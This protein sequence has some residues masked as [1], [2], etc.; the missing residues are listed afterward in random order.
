MSL[1]VGVIGAGDKA[2]GLLKSLATFTGL[3]QHG[4]RPLNFISDQQ[5]SNVLSSEQIRNMFL[6]GMTHR[7]GFLVNSYELTGPVHIPP[8]SICEPRQLP[9][10]G[11]ET[12]PV[13][14][15]D[16]LEGTWI[17]ICSYTGDCQRVC[18]PEDIRKTDWKTSCET[19]CLRFFIYP[20]AP[21][22]IFLICCATNPQKTKR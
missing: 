6:L 5:Y 21:S 15:C 10:E 19:W 1:R 13:C 7:P 22:L 18:V 20:R 17:G 14:N 2:G 3:F 16:L 4:G 9:L 8:F 11:L 12:L